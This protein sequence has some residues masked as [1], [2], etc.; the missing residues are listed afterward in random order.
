MPSKI[1]STIPHIPA[2]KKLG[3]KLKSAK[4]EEPIVNDSQLSAHLENRKKRPLEETTHEPTSTP[5]AQLSKRPKKASSTPKSPK[6][7][8]PIPST[9]TIPPF[10][11]SPPSTPAPPKR[12]SVSFTPETKTTDGDSIK[13]LYN[14]WLASQKATDPTFNPASISDSLKAVQPAQLHPTTSPTPT[15][16]KSKKKARKSPTNLTSSQKDPPQPQTQH[17]ALSYLT[18]HHT[19]PQS[20]KFSKNHQTHLLKHLFS[21]THIPPPHN[22]ALHS[23]LLGLRGLSAR[24][25]LRATA[26]EIR[27]RDEEEVA[28][29]ESPDLR[30]RYYEQAVGVFREKLRQGE[31][32]REEEGELEVEE[33]WK[34][35][36]E[37]RRRAEVVLWAVG[38]TEEEVGARKDG[39]GALDTGSEGRAMGT[40]GNAEVPKGKAKR[41]RKRRTEVPDDDT[42]SSSESSSGSSSSSE[43]GKEKSTGRSEGK[44]DESSDS[45]SSESGGSGA[46]SE[47][48]SSESG[49]D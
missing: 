9:S 16:P 38:E 36:V 49:S 42:S 22:Q 37:R 47:D 15:P 40:T 11:P 45:S 3:L 2:W 14:T 29:M 24:A 32:A 12:K 30:R 7:D 21:P 4:D 41:K 34:E 25:R 28:G 10:N 48:S 13:A 39:K 20:W 6:V 1:E 18:T 43:D 17:P 19:D 26:L 23:Y 33:E 31:W 5:P 8:T 35:R 46:D 27:K 44:K